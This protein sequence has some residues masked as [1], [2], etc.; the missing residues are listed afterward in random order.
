MSSIRDIKRYLEAHIEAAVKVP[1]RRAKGIVVG[2]PKRPSEYDLADGKNTALKIS[3]DDRTYLVL[4]NRKD[5][6]AW[7]VPNLIGSA[8]LVIPD[9]AETTKD[10]LPALN[11]RWGF[12]FTENDILDV[13]IEYRGGSVVIPMSG[14]NL[15]FTGELLLPVWPVEEGAYVVPW[16]PRPVVMP[17]TTGNLARE[18]MTASILTYTVDYTAISAVCAAVPVAPTR[19]WANADNAKLIAL[20]QAMRGVDGLPWYANTVSMGAYNLAYSHCL[21]NG[22]TEGFRLETPR[23]GTSWHGMSIDQDNAYGRYDQ[24]VNRKMRSVLVLIVNHNYGI[25]NMNGLLFI[26]YDGPAIAFDET[27]YRDPLYF[28]PLRGDQKSF[29]AG[30]PDLNLPLNW[31]PRPDGLTLPALQTTGNYPLGVSLPTDAD[32]TLTITLDVGARTA[33]S[34]MGLFGDASGGNANGAI[35]VSNLNL[36]SFVGVPYKW[37]ATASAAELIY[38]HRITVTIVRKGRLIRTYHN[39]KLVSLSEVPAGYVTVPITHFGKVSEFLA[40]SFIFFD[41]G[42]FDYA[43]SAKQVLEFKRSNYGRAE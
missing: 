32:F 2:V 33:G 40:N 43:L 35:K 28:W 39:G 8:H 36:I 41:L 42:Y 22:P 14:T 25:S 15:W 12:G 10:L 26:H 7:M 1:L 5:I 24:Y 17:N 16:E 19:A 29:I 11:R 4:Y 31:W 13:P 6:Q 9:T 37:Y 18:S 27:P 34:W 23:L 21:Y 30:K 3:Y 20:T 38:M